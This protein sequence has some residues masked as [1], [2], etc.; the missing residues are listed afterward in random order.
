MTRLLIVSN[1]LP[2]T[3]KVEQGAVSLTRSAGGLATAL[4]G[5]HEKHDALWIGWPGDVSRLTDEQRRTVDEQLAAA[6]T[7]PV[8]LS[9]QQIA[10]YYDGFSNGVLWPL[11][12]Y[13]VDKVQLDARRDFHVY[14]E[15]NQ[16]FAN[17]VVEQYREGD[18][19]WVHDYQLA[20]VP[21]MLRE[22]LPNARIG[23]FLHIPF[24]SSEVFRV[25]PWREQVLRGLLGADL[26]GF[27]TA[28]FRHNF[29]YS[30]ARVLGIEPDFD[31]V[32]H[33]DR[34]VRLGV[35][36][37]S[38][39][40]TELEDLA[41]TEA[42]ESEM[43]RFRED[44]RLLVL[45]VDRFDYTKGIPRRLLGFERFLERSGEYRKKVRFVQIA[46]PT[47]EKVD[48]YAE[49]RR[50]AN[51]LVGRIN[52]QFGGV[53]GVPIHFLHRAIAPEQ[54]VALYRAA[55]VMLV[56]PLRDG[57]N[58]VAKEFV[59][60]RI[61][62]DGA[63]VLSEFAGA[64][65]ELS[66]AILVNPYD[67]D[68]IASSIHHA[69]TMS[70]S[71]RRA[72]MRAMRGYLRAHDVH[73]W[74]QSFLDDLAAEPPRQ[75]SRVSI[76]PSNDVVERIRAAEHVTLL[77]DYDGTLV[78]H[79]PTPELALPDEDLL[80]LVT[81]LTERFDVHIVTG[82]LRESIEGFF[83][84]LPVTL[85]AEHGFW[86]RPRR[87]EWTPMQRDERLWM[88]EAR[89]VIK[90]VAARTRGSMVEEKSASLAFHYRRVD[91]ELAAARLRE[92]RYLLKDLVRVHGLELLSGSKVVE[93][94]AAGVNKSLAVQ[95]VEPGRLIVAIG[96]D[97][98]DEDMFAAL[99]D[100]AIAIH[101]GRGETRAQYRLAN[102]REVRRLLTSVAAQR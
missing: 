94:R 87:G 3:A 93:L 24:P 57:M 67:L 9:P 15:V 22:R 76:V 65:D 64:A 61:D 10:R 99:P 39:D 23:F 8:H 4:R 29:A 97:R 86:H 28:S 82:R 68:A 51:E 6:R 48:A 80:Q 33:E 16:I 66:Q 96:D 20:L 11:F 42:V 88:H 74:A 19:I 30:A 54:L 32:H 60:S 98:T 38:I 27:H 53:N 78:E 52:G 7:V 100:G 84:E 36:P 56:T 26:L 79:A 95:R 25:L 18:S 1:R 47:R 41:R 55:D 102:V 91:P 46:V 5:P 13:L 71:E 35:Y 2:L 21:Q 12:H 58:L 73:A 85:H 44:P 59:A 101:V 89:A 62:D 69:L 14:T 31:V 45:G 90:T 17:K 63:L 92:L 72:R 70:P 77:L 75:P 40:V 50:S 49:L 43:K 34:H 81:R 83:G 37:I